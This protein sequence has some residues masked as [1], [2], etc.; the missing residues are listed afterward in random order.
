MLLQSTWPFIHQ[1][2]N[3]LFA[4]FGMKHKRNMAHA[5]LLHIQWNTISLSS[6][7]PLEQALDM[8]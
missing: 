8:W 3:M 1:A 6:V 2:I 4:I 7:A 5:K